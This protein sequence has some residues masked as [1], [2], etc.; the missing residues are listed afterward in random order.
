MMTTCPE[1]GSSEIISDLLVFA[2]KALGGQ[3]PPYVQLEEQ[4]LQKH[5]CNV[6]FLL[7]SL[8]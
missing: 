2:D 7:A 8:A 3:Y 1:C 5:R 4:D 6:K